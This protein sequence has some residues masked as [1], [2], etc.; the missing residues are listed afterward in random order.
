[1]ENEIK[2]GSKVSFKDGEDTF[3]GTVVENCYDNVYKV[4]VDESYLVVDADCF[5]TKENKSDEPILQ[6][7]P[8][9]PK[10][11]RKPVK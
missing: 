11:G 10:R 9:K 4:K 6:S 7:E 5:N 3:E 8:P 2:I 1:M